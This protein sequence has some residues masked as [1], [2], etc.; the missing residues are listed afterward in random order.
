MKNMSCGQSN[1]TGKAVRAA[2]VSLSVFAVSACMGG[3][4]IWQ[5]EEVLYEARQEVL[6]RDVNY[7]NDNH[8]ELRD[9]F[10]ALERLYVE[11]VHEIRVQTAKMSALEGKMANVEENP[12][13]LARLTKM[14]ND[15][16]MMRDQ[17]KKLENRVFSVEMSETSGSAAQAASSPVASTAQA[18]ATTNLGSAQANTGAPSAEPSVPVNNNAAPKQSFFGV[19]LASYRSKDQV[20][21]GWAGLR[22]SFGNSLEGLTPLIY[23]QSQEGIGTFLRL[24]AGPLISEQ[25]ANSLCSRIKEEA[26]EQYCRVSEYQGEPVE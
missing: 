19:H 4:E 10:D 14:R 25:E 12:E 26:S 16:S 24:I 7:V 23:T 18:P 15:V 22:D 21:S 13:A 20:D 8:R 9:R 17:M 6:E 5:G 3:G 11:L 2:A 1:F